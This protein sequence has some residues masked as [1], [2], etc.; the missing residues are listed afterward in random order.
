VASPSVTR[1]HSRTSSSDPR[2]RADGDGVLR[3]TPDA[4]KWFEYCR[5][6]VPLYLDL[7]IPRKL[8]L[9]HHI[10]SCALFGRHADVEFL[11]PGAG[12]SSGVANRTTRPEG[13]SALGE[14]LEYFDQPRA[15]ATSLRH[16]T[17]PVHPG[18]MAFLLAAYDE[19]EV[20]G[21]KRTVL[22]L[23]PRPLLTRWRSCPCR[24]TT[25]W[26]AVGEVSQLHHLH[27][28]LRREPV[29]RKRYRRQDEVGTPFCV[30]VDFDSLETGPSPCASAIRPS[31]SVPI[32]ALATRSAGASVADTARAGARRRTSKVAP[33]AQ[34]FRWTLRRS[35]CR[36][37]TTIDQTHVVPPMNK[38]SR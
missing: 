9:R 11:F 18:M 23:D 36:S 35:S 25:P 29:D 22:R 28:R 13:H 17:G 33:V 21:E 8:R 5:R 1:S 31:R 37:S 30:T 15:S 20:G 32:D 4:Q 24:R 3:A 14:K 16:R 34:R 38:T 2:V 26:S 12:T 19:D 6:A 27:V 7:G 10:H